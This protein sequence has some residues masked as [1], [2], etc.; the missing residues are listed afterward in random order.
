MGVEA[1]FWLLGGGGS[2][3]I[4][5][6]SPTPFS[7]AFSLTHHHHHPQPTP[8]RDSWPSWADDDHGKN[9]YLKSR[10]A[11]LL[12]T[13]DKRWSH[14]TD[15]QMKRGRKKEKEEEVE[16]GAGASYRFVMWHGSVCASGG[17]ASQLSGVQDQ[18]SGAALCC[19]PLCSTGPAGDNNT[20][21]L[22]G[23]I[24]PSCYNYTKHL[25]YILNSQYTCA[26]ETTVHPPTPPFLL[27]DFWP[28]ISW[29]LASYLDSLLQLSALLSLLLPCH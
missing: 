4:H 2:W 29:S 19:G 23:W 17:N 10:A 16:E 22:C 21:G 6:N 13:V 1:L 18:A 9:W 11:A 28:S 5:H 27:S 20:A 3:L 25:N 24:V 8:R 14:A 12:H 26:L 7:S 15:P